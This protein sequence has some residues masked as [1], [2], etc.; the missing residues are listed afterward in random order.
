VT[1]ALNVMPS[2][3]VQL[4]KLIELIEPI[5]LVRPLPL[6]SE[7][8]AAEELQDSDVPLVES[9]SVVVPAV[10]VTD[11]PGVTVQVVAANAGAALRENA[12][13]AT[14]VVSRAPPRR[15]SIG[16]SFLLV[17]VLFESIA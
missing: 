11:P 9:V 14:A 15:L 8:T 7:P 12:A 10:P 5:G 1:L 6:E 13:A 3:P 16:I 17:L 4:L 2:G